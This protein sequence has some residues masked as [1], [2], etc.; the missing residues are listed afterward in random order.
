M[1]KKTEDKITWEVKTF[2]DEKSGDLILP[3]P[4]ELLERMGWREGDTLNWGQDKQGN[5]ILSKK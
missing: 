4:P 2:E 3:L 1:S 5:W